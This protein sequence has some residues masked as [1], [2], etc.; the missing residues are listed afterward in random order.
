MTLATSAQVAPQS[1]RIV[2]IELGDSLKTVG[3]PELRACLE[4]LAGALAASSG[5]P[6]VGS[7][8]VSS[9]EA[10]R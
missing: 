3:D 2:P 1:L 8:V 7:G 4:S 5:V 9:G 6:V 10:E